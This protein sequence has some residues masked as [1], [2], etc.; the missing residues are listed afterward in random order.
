MINTK[1]GVDLW[2]LSSTMTCAVRMIDA[3]LRHHGYP[4]WTITSTTE[5]KHMTG[6]RHYTGDAIDIRIRDVSDPDEFFILIRDALPD[7]FDVILERDHVH[8]E[9]DPRKV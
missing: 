7:S 1:P 3:Q 9:F 5:G 8:V 4:S 6:S 2:G